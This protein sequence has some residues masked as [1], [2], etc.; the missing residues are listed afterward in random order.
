MRLRVGAAARGGDHAVC[1]G[2]STGAAVFGEELVAG[3]RAETALSAC[4]HATAEVAAA[5]APACTTALAL[6]DRRV[7]LLA[8]LLALTAIWGRSARPRRRAATGFVTASPYTG[9]PDDLRATVVRARWVWREMSPRRVKLRTPS[10]PGSEPSRSRVSFADVRL[11]PAL[12]T[13]HLACVYKSSSNSTPSRRRWRG[14]RAQ[15]SLATKF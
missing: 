11:A 1:F 7:G 10:A 14:A 4:H 6:R 3:F 2:V 15:S 5:V 13:V 8:A 12:A 9:V